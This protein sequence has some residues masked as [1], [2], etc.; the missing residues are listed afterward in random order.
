MLWQDSVSIRSS[1]ASTDPSLFSSG[2]T[3]PA[4]ECSQPFDDVGVHNTTLDPEA[5]I[6]YGE[7]ATPK[8]LFS[9]KGFRQATKFA[10]RLVT[11]K[12]EWTMALLGRYC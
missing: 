9:S 12:V 4:D 6:N 1:S 3:T 5:E 11:P 10:Q 7:I 8:P 2:L